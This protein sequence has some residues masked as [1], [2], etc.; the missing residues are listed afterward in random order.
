MCGISGI[1]IF[2]QKDKNLLQDVHASIKTLHRRGP[3]NIAVN[4]HNN[5]ALGHARLSIIDT[6]EAA[7]QPF[8][9]ACGNYELI[10]NGEIFNFKDLRSELEKKGNT[11]KTNSDTEVLLQLFI[12]E[13]EQCLNKLNGFFAFCIYDK[14]NE[15]LFLARDRYGIKPLLYYQDETLFCF[16]SELK[17][18]SKYAFKK[19]ISK[20]AL[21]LYFQLGYIPSPRSI[22]ENVKKLEPGCWIKINLNKLEI[23]RYYSIPTT[24]FEKTPDY[25]EAKKTVRNLVEKSVERRLIADV[26]LGSFLS[27]GIDSSV[28][29]T[30]ASKFTNNLNTF[31]IGYKDE[32]FFDETHYAEL[33]A[34]KIKSNHTV[35]SLTNDDLF[36]HFERIVNY[37][38]EP[39]ADSSAIA[40]NILCHYTKNKVT[41]A[42]SGD[43]ADELFSGYNKHKA[44]YLSQQN[45]LK[46]L[47]LKNSQPL[48]KV[49]PQSR[50]NAL[51]NK[52]RQ[53]NRYASGLNLTPK[54]RYWKWAT[55]QS[56]SEVSLLLKKQ[57]H[58]N[59]E[60]LDKLNNCKNINEFL[61]NDFNLVLEGDM[62]KKVDSMSMAN[63]LEVRV[64]F[65]D[66]ELVN[67]V[68]QLPEHYKI[69]AH[70]TK[71]ILKDTFKNDLPEELYTRKK[72]GFEVPLKKW[73]NNELQPIIN[74]LLD[75]DFI[76]NQNIFNYDRIVYLR[77][78]SAS[79]N[80]E[81]SISV[82]WM[83]IVFQKWYKNYFLA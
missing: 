36:E 28:V 60:F 6:S 62:L 81:D 11:F 22:Y 46:N 30:V 77:K 82:L 25:E 41:V 5:V 54:E 76:E 66:F 43:G 24:T 27:G 51:G 9:S 71:K 23:G 29:A 38:D 50:N 57:F 45:N 52:L 34:K 18:L 14:K 17:A 75:K 72:H 65:L 12:E 78:K 79:S 40:V 15:A 10:F 69:D 33:V 74:E 61:L 53:L 8:V 63:S 47:L 39:F 42:L 3:D 19:S 55:L 21:Q 2:N 20:E 35:F 83:L 37:M 80:P 7:N 64:P 56:E 49:F 58:T 67:Y 70:N 59:F 48:L 68:F 32:P 16:A 1:N 73:M 31:S 4:I 13:K 44:F 26:P